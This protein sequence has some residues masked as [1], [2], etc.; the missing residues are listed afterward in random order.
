MPVIPALLPEPVIDTE[1]GAAS[2]LTLVPPD[3]R[4]QGPAATREISVLIADGHA[5]LRA[6]F[7]LAFALL[8]A[9]AAR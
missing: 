5:L 4:V 8:F 7:Y 6:A 3:G 2:R 9:W 1:L